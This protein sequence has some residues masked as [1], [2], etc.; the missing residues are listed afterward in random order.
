M[1]LSC[2]TKIFAVR[3]S[4][5]LAF[6]RNLRWRALVTR[7]QLDVIPCVRQANAVPKIF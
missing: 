2:V 4:L 6:A 7:L 3:F 1:V 5:R